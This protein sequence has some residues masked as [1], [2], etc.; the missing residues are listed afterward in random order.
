MAFVSIINRRIV[1][2]QPQQ[3]VQCIDYSADEELFLAIFAYPNLVFNLM[4]R[5]SLRMGN[6]AE[7]VDLT[8]EAVCKEMKLTE[9]SPSVWRGSS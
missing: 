7:G 9:L 8:N 5:R 1:L 3:Q 4:A 2:Q 6:G